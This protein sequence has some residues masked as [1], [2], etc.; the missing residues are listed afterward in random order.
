MD[1]IGVQVVNV[2]GSFMLAAALQAAGVPAPFLTLV[3][4][5]YQVVPSITYTTQQLGDV[6]V[7]SILNSTY[8]TT[9]TPTI[10]LAAVNTT[11]FTALAQKL[12]ASSINLDFFIIER[13]FDKSA[14]ETA[15]LRKQQSRLSKLVA[16]EA[17][18]A[19]SVVEDSTSTVPSTPAALQALPIGAAELI[20]LVI[21]VIV[22]ASAVVYVRLSRRESGRANADEPQNGLATRHSNAEVEIDCGA[23]PAVP[24]STV[25][26][27]RVLDDVASSHV[28]RDGGLETSPQPDQPPQIASAVEDLR[29]VTERTPQPIP[30][31]A[32]FDDDTNPSNQPD[33][34]SPSRTASP[35]PVDKYVLQPLT[36]DTLML[37]NMQRVYRR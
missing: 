8:T 3:I 16:Q 11:N 2:V 37:T 23:P 10:P 18:A 20:L 28:E 21:S 33:S 9:A 34:S 29:S 36:F 13:F 14:L 7:L 17:R 1:D 4:G 24:T 31:V 12:P 26:D 30:E 19:W 27:E 6:A 35:T 32:S 22:I 15:I 25:D 5:S